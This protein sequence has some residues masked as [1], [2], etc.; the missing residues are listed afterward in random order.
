[1]A[2]RTGFS[3]VSFATS[4]CSS[5]SM[6][7]PGWSWLPLV[8]RPSILLPEAR[9]MSG[10]LV[11]NVGFSQGGASWLTEVHQ[12]LRPGRMGSQGLG[13]VP[14]QHQSGGPVRL[15]APPEAFAGRAGILKGPQPQSATLHFWGHCGRSAQVVPAAPLKPPSQ[16]RRH[17]SKER[18]ECTEI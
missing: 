9:A 16:E 11:L 14:K 2:C 6:F 13:Y 12:S 7:C 8:P 18:C 10:L 3:G 4:S 17:C 15:C 5:Y 1:M